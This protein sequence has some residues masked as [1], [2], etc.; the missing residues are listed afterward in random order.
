MAI[1]EQ[2]SAGTA[3]D[4]D[5]EAEARDRERRSHGCC[6]RCCN[7]RTELTTMLCVD[8]F[9][10]ASGL[11]EWPTGASPGLVLFFRLYVYGVVGPSIG[12]WLLALRA[13]GGWARRLLC[14]WMF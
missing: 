4:M 5:V 11:A 10:A 2:S 12:M 3:P 6:C 8:L 13:K 14:R 1:G 7:V 9:I